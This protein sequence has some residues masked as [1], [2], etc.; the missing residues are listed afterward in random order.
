[1]QWEVAQEQDIVLAFVK[2]QW[3]WSFLDPPKPTDPA[4]KKR[5][6]RTYYI[7]T[8]KLMQKFPN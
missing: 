8:A 1:M 6:Y 7:M 4:T 2:R 5:K 3:L